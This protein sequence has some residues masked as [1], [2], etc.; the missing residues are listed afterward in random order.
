MDK[1]ATH[2]ARA[3]L[4]VLAGRDVLSPVAKKKQQQQQQ[5]AEGQQEGGEAAAEGRKANQQVG[6]VRGSRVQAVHRLLVFLSFKNK[7]LAVGC[8]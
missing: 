3:L 2:V 4:V 6:G 1:H 5:Q 7:C 8:K